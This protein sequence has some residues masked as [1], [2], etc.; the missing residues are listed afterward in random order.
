MF[1]QI[2]VVIILKKKE[3]ILCIC[4]LCCVH[5]VYCRHG[6]IRDPAAIGLRKLYSLNVFSKDRYMFCVNHNNIQKYI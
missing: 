4:R 6:R 2:N 3:A 1:V 5:G